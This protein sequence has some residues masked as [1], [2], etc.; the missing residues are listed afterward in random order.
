MGAASWTL[1]NIFSM[2]ESQGQEWAFYGSVGFTIPRGVQEM[3]G[4]LWFILNDGVL[5]KAGLNK[6][7]GEPGGIAD[8]KHFRRAQGTAWVLLW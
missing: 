1:G 8:S 3:T 6:L 7:V 2:K 4:L 5:S